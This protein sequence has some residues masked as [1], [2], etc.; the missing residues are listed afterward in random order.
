M[1]LVKC[2]ECELQVSDKA[3]ACPHCGY[4]LN[5]PDQPKG[6]GKARPKHRRLPNG[7][8]SITELKGRN[9]RNPFW[10]RVCVGKS[11]Y[12]KPILKSLKPKAYF[13][14]YNDAYAALCE[15]N[16][17][18]YDLDNDMTICEL[19][20]KWTDVYLKDAS[21]AY[22]R[23][24]SSAW[25][26][27]SSVY[28]MRAKDLR[29]RHVKGCMDQGYRIESKGK[30]KGEKVYPSATTKT[31][32]KSLFNVML[33]YAL[34][35]E[36][37]DRNYART[38]DVSDDIIKEAQESKRGHIPFDECELQTLWD[39]VHK[40]KFA[41]WV[42]IQCYMGWRPQELATLRLEEVNLDKWYMQAGMKTDAGKQRIVPIHSKIR[43]LVKQNYDFALSIGSEYLFN[44]K[45]QTHAGSWA[46][47]YDKYSNRFRKVMEQLQ[48]GSEHRPHDPRNTFITNGK[49]AKMDEYA[50]KEMVGHSV[51]DITES[52]YTMRD[53]EWLRKDIEKLK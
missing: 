46:V 34:E 16:K 8:G 19:Y 2:P 21:D 44:D 7:F 14:T 39:N 40:V 47:T 23:T 41:D 51:Q 18:P 35:Y 49:K 36:I 27:C 26:Y 22:A 31:K 37:V 33:D 5:D 20:D 50:L 4:P 42:I 17:N 24:I 28:S 13:R 29:A 10:A 32:I 30:R 38:F 15:Y 1:A 48:L 12:G 52:A 43:K 11:A 9:L 25:A 45:G 53:L 3:I 6:R